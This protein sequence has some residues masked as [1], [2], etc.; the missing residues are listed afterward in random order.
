MGQTTTIPAYWKP[1]REQADKVNAKRAAIAAL[2][3][4]R[5]ARLAGRAAIE[6]K[7]S[8]STRDLIATVTGGKS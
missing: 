6:S 7:V 8:A 5:E 2:R 4:S 1:T 3:Q